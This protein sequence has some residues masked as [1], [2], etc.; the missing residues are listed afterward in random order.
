MSRYQ[1][2]MSKNWKA[3]R[4]GKTTLECIKI[5][6]EVEREGKDKRYSLFLFLI[7]ETNPYLYNIR[8]KTWTGNEYLKGEGKGIKQNVE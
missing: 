4:G 2:T 7:Y 3:A 6:Y 5:I 1:E 8:I